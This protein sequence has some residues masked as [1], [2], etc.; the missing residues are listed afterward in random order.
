MGTKNNI[1]KLPKPGYFIW[2]FSNEPKKFVLECTPGIRLD[3]HGIGNIKTRNLANS[4]ILVSNIGFGA[5]DMSW[6]YGIRPDR[7][8]MIQLLGDIYTMGNRYILDM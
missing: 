8:D 2:A 1:L 7:P 4:E 6:G 5:M 3:L